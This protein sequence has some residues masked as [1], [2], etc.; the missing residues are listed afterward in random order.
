MDCSGPPRK[1]STR[2]FYQ[3]AHVWLS[4]AQLWFVEQKL[5]ALALTSSV[6]IFSILHT[7]VLVKVSYA[8][9]DFSTSL[10]EKQPD[11]FYDAIFRFF[12]IVLVAA[13]L[14]A[15]H[16]YLE[17]RLIIEWRTYLTRTLL[18]KYFRNRA[19]FRLQLLGTFC[20]RTSAQLF[21]LLF[22]CWTVLHPPPFLK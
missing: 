7:L 5:R 6:V 2:P 17:E 18:D 8:Q 4:V 14:F 19:Y 3:V 1:V 9:R 22:C 16:I 21:F 15:V 13:P 11:D 12:C 20:D 10:A